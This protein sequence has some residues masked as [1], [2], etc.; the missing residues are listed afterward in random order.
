MRDIPRG[1]RNVRDHIFRLIWQAD[2]DQGRVATEAFRKI[3]NSFQGR[4]NGRELADGLTE[5]VDYYTL[6]GYWRGYREAKRHY[7]AMEKIDKTPADRTRV[8]KFVEQIFRK[9]PDTSTKDVCKALDESGLSAGFGKDEF[10]GPRIGARKANDE[11]KWVEGCTEQ[12]VVQWIHRIRKWVKIEKLASAWLN[13]SSEISGRQSNGAPDFPGIV[14]SKS[15]K[16]QPHGYK[17]RSA[18]KNP[19]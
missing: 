5:I 2:P 7:E 16:H 15:R 9:N 13:R 18:E 14:P 19:D 3:L 10:F 1:E 4:E 17:N 12:A 6:L 11:E 8:A